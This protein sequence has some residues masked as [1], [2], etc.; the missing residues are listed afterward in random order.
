MRR[1]FLRAAALP[2][3]AVLLGAYYLLFERPGPKATQAPPP[4]L[5]IFPGLSP[6][7]ISRIELRTPD[8]TLD[9]VKREGKWLLESQRKAPAN[10]AEIERLI[11]ILARAKYS[12]KA[13][14]DQLGDDLEQFGLTNPSL[15]V[16]VR[17]DEPSRQERPPRMIRFGRISPSGALVYA[18]ATHQ[19]ELLLIDADVVNHLKYFLFVPPLER[20]AVRGSVAP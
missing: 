8:L 11:S 4:S 17:S 15:T 10:Q 13:P 14:L 12:R 1:S 2:T 3:I 20:R 5:L 9:A 7:H 6:E 18:V 16:S 19:E